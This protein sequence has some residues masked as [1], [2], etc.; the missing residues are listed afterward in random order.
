MT[1]HET[2]ADRRQQAELTA[3]EQAGASSVAEPVVKT[4]AVRLLP[5]DDS[6][7]YA[8]MIGVIRF[9]MTDVKRL[10]A[11]RK[12]LLALLED[13]GACAYVAY[14][15]DDL[16][17][18]SELG[19]NGVDMEDALVGDG[20]ILV[21]PEDVLDDGSTENSE[22]SRVYTHCDKIALQREGFSFVT[23]EDDTDVR[24]FSELVPYE[25]IFEG[26]L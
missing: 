9:S 11:R 20:R 24:Y 14:N 18:Y 7:N 16:C 10:A 25:E 13:D 12:H 17:S 23:F 4:L 6:Y 1:E 5:S 21:R 26:V 19:L 3:A 15:F 22:G 8:T 2:E